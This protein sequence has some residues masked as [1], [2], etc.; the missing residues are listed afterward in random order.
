MLFNPLWHKPEVKAD[1]FALDTL[2]AWLERHDPKEHYAYLSCHCCLLAQYFMDQGFDDASVA[3]AY[4][5]YGGSFK[6][7]P[8]GFNWIAETAPHSFGKALARARFAKTHPQEVE[9]EQK[10]EQ[11]YDAEENHWRSFGV[12][13]RGEFLVSLLGTT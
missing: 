11:L 13:A 2:I 7:L 1:P 10:R 12:P 6:S 9:A 4:F 3:R 5:C 8:P